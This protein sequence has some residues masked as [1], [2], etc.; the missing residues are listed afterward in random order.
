MLSSGV[1]SCA[2][3]LDAR[4]SG[5]LSVIVNGDPHYEATTTRT[6][7]GMLLS[8]TGRSGTSLEVTQTV[9]V[10][11]GFGFGAS[12]ASALSGVRAVAAALRLELS[13]EQ[14]AFHAHAADIV[15]RTGLGTVSVIYRYGGAGVI[16][17]AGAPGLAEVKQVR[18]PADVRIVTASLA[19]YRKSM[20]L[21]SSAETKARVND[22]CAQALR[23][24]SDLKVES[25]VH[26]GEF[27]ADNLG[28]ESPDVKR[29]LGQARSAGAIGASQNMVGHSVHALVPSDQVPRFVSLLR[30]DVSSPTVQ[31]W[32]LAP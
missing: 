13:P 7:I 20:V 32:D 28:L 17:G 9:E 1:R 27:F 31:V 22:L 5:D 16:V 10:P 6:A 3:I 26:A 29:L 23:M 4:G 30:S 11:I 15:C 14:L 24:A 21:S 8:A 18:V 19:P 12:A 2:R 25:L